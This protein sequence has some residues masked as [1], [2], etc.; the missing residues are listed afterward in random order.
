LALFNGTSLTLTNPGNTYSGPTI[1]GAGKAA[2]ALI[3]GANDAFSANS[4]VL[5]GA[6]PAKAA[7]R[8]MSILDSS[9]GKSPVA[10]RSEIGR[11]SDP[12]SKADFQNVIC[13][14]ESWRPSHRV[15]SLAG[16][17]GF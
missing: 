11:N 1:I 2:S 9:I 7:D 13:G 4:A 15:P 12:K 6:R 17:S 10:L 3:G 5:V 14:F 8:W 16:V